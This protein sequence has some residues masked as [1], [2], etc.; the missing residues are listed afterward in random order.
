MSCFFFVFFFSVFFGGRAGGGGGVTRTNVVPKSCRAILPVPFR[1]PSNRC[2]RTCSRKS[3]LPKGHDTSNA[4]PRS[5]NG[6]PRPLMGPQKQP[7]L[8][9]TTRKEHIPLDMG[10]ALFVV[11]QKWIPFPTA[12]YKHILK[13]THISQRVGQNE[14]TRI[15]TAGFNLPGLTPFWGLQI[16]DPHPHVTLISSG[17]LSL[18]SR[19][20]EDMDFLNATVLPRLLA[21]A[22]EERTSCSGRG[23][24][25]LA[26]SVLGVDSCPGSLEASSNTTWTKCSRA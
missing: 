15:W 14:S 23:H 13:L 19:S 11:S 22:A 2:G 18:S 5:S 26:L 1:L 9:T 10:E 12:L 17:S 20:Q 3:Y 21:R 25:G 7:I 16:F 8:K 4:A 6:E 24:A